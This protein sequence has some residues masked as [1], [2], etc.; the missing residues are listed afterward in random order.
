M[1][2]ADTPSKATSFKLMGMCHA[3]M[4]LAWQTKPKRPK[5]PPCMPAKIDSYMELGSVIV[6][7]EYHTRYILKKLLGR[8]A[9]AQCYLV[10]IESGEQ[11]AIKIVRLK[12]ITSKKVHEKLD[13]E[14]AIHSRLDNPNIVK[15][16]RS[17]R[18]E[19]YV[20][21]VLELCERGALDALLKRNGRLKERY[22]AKFIKQTVDGLLYLHNT[23]SIVHR[24][25][26][27]GNL[28]L[29]AKLNVKI[30]DFGLSAVIKDGEKKVTMCGTPNYIA[31]EILFGKASGHSFEADV[32]SLGVIIYT[33]LVGVPPFQK[34]NV[35]DIYKMIKQNN[36][37]FPKECDLS[38]EAI[39]LITQILNTN[40]LERPALEHI[41]SHRFLSRKEH[42]LMRIYRSLVSNRTQEGGVDG[43]Y[44]IFSI[45]VT[46]LRGIG[47]V[48]RSGVYGIYFGDHR[49]LMLRP[50]KRSVIYLNSTIENGRR[51][52]YKEEHLIEKIPEEVVE[53]YKALQYF[54]RTFDS[55]FVFISIEPC[56]IVK[57]KKFESGFLFVMADSTIVFDFINGWKVVISKCGEKALCYNGMGAVPFSQEVRMRCIDVL[58]GCFGNA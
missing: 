16:Y 14:I 37:I 54:I 49:N 51:V 40:P 36:Y 55:G 2:S 19:E 11:Y 22:V 6:D 30:G 20:F 1:P 24:D 45:P 46:K 32:W 52:F 39:D 7:P 28:F 3:F 48:L 57:I 5:I 58:K 35:E 15:M 26:K 56:F 17:F 50:N 41:L 9:Y 8:G 47:Y 4:A 34:K 43:D 42:F 12:D 21:M 23:M 31:P 10:S 53:S 18:S 27:L 33:L 25:L 44:V 13:S 29:D 38:S